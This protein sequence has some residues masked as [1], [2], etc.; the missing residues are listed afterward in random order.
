MTLLWIKEDSLAKSYL[1]H[2]RWAK[3]RTGSLSALEIIF[4]MMQAIHFPFSFTSFTFPS[5]QF[6]FVHQALCL[7]V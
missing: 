1:R 2:L 7:Q 3:S 6:N 4:L 5:S